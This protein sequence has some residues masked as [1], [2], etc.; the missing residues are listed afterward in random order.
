MVKRKGSRVPNDDRADSMGPQVRAGRAESAGKSTPNDDRADSMG[1]QVRAGGGGGPNHAGHLGARGDMDGIYP[2]CSQCGHRRYKIINSVKICR[3]CDYP[4][5]IGRGASGGQVKGADDAGSSGQGGM[6]RQGSHSAGGRASPR[7]IRGKVATAH[8]KFHSSALER[9]AKTICDAHRGSKLDDLLARAGVGESRRRGVSGQ[10]HLY[11]VF[12]RLQEGNGH[13]RIMGIL[14]A[15]CGTEAGRAI[16]EE[17]NECLEP[18]SRRID[19]GGKAGWVIHGSAPPGDDDR[20]FDQRRY[21]QIVIRSA[22]AKFAKGE[23]TSAVAEACKALEGLVRKKS[24]IDNSGVSLMEMAFGRHA[25]LAVDLPELSDET[26]T[27]VQRGLQFMCMG[28]MSGVRNPVSHEP[29]ASLRIGRADALD[30]LGVISHLCRQVEGTRRVPGAKHGLPKKGGGPG[31]NAGARGSRDTHG[32]SRDNSGEDPGLQDGARPAASLG[33][34]GAGTALE[35][36][37]T[38]SSQRG[39]DDGNGN[40]DYDAK[41]ELAESERLL[42]IRPDD[43]GARVRRGAALCELGRHGEAIP[44]LERAVRLA[45]GDAEAHCELGWALLFGESDAKALRAF[46]EAVSLGPSHFDSHLGRGTALHAMG[47]HA[48]ALSAFDRAVE[49]DPAD[50][51]G[52]HGRATALVGLGRHAEAKEALARSIGADPE[53]AAAHMDMALALHEEHDSGAALESCNRAIGLDA[54]LA[55][56][57]VL[58]AK[59]MLRLERDDSAIEDCNH[60]LS[61]DPANPGA[62]YWRG[63]ARLAL[64]KGE[65]ALKDLESACSLDPNSAELH[66]ARGDALLALGRHDDALSAY[67]NALCI[68]PDDPG[69]RMSRVVAFLKRGKRAAALSACRSL[70]RRHPDNSDVHLH[71]GLVYRELG[72]HDEALDAFKRAARLDP[73][74]MYPKTC[75]VLT[76]IELGRADDLLELATKETV[77]RTGEAG[78]RWFRASCLCGLGRHDEA[79]AEIDRAIGLNPD[80]AGCRLDKGSILERLGRKDEANVAYSAALRAADLEIAKSPH[81]GAAHMMRGFALRALGREDEA[82]EAHAQAVRLEP[83]LAPLIRHIP[84]GAP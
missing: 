11:G 56:A 43:A 57:Y 46:D 32:L 47:R 26:R 71:M 64:G 18:Y 16:R 39:L 8:I 42:S 68:V 55:D 3:A 23:H 19:E 82:G 6:A 7:V 53:N 50:P 75:M 13:D 80:I 14:G 35:A 4:E 37:N 21:H 77:D 2:A 31:P 49:T 34:A 51:E 10:E 62:L 79:L 20:E 44:E 1:P 17:V 41:R 30:M 40:G 63:A 52:H 81:D 73:D 36:A 61:L 60:A 67:D 78:S 76:L 66:K 72:R 27:N 9:L 33:G 29:E 22:R 69:V 70:M 45:Q 84:Q 15:A 28:V 58:R 25:R 38:P 12:A 59:I 24:G 65:D 5:P 83:G 48:E 54:Y 74:G